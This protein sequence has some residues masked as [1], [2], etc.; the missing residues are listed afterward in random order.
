MG[1]HICPGR[2]EWNEF[3]R[4]REVEVKTLAVLLFKLWGIIY[5]ISSANLSNPRT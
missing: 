1:G 2:L 5:C 3:F 4:K